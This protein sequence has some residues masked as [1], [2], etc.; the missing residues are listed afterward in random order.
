MAGF[1][2]VTGVEDDNQD[3]MAPLDMTQAPMSDVLKVFKAMGDN[4][5]IIVKK[6]D[7]GNIRLTDSNKD[8]EYL[9]QMDGMDNTDMPMRAQTNENVLYELS[10]ANMT[11]RLIQQIRVVSLERLLLKG[12]TTKMKMKMKMKSF[13]N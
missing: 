7:V 9:I 4:D 3:A 12:G 5:G 1:P 8:S 10:M 2:P 6:D 13:M 11:N